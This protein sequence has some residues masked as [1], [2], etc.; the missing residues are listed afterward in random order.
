MALRKRYEVTARFGA[1]SSTGT[2]GEIVETGCVPDGALELPVGL[3]RQRPPAY[4]AVK[5]GR[6]PGV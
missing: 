3:V 6:P 2:R 5:V 4:S 1:T